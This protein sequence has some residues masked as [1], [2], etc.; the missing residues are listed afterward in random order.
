[1]NNLIAYIKK[2][3]AAVPHIPVGYVDA[4]YM[5]VNYQEIV[6]V[7]DVIFVNCYPFWE[8][9]AL[10]ISVEYMKKMYELA[11]SLK[12]LMKHEKGHMI[13]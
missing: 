12:H 9:C 5:F 4:D 7:C 1:L 6:D 3:K 10:D 2:V 11:F 13:L 8:H